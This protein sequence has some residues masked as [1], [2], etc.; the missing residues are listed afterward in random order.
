MDGE[1]I[2][3]YEPD[4]S[5]KKGYL[6]IFGEIFRELNDNRWLTY[7]L[8]KRDFVSAYKQSFIGILWVVIIPIVSLGTFMILNRSG[9]FSV[10]EIKVPYPVYALLGMSFWQIF[11]SGLIACSNS[12]TKAGAMI[13]KINFSKKSLVLAAMGQSAISFLIQACLVVIVMALYRIR[14]NVMALTFP[15][16]LVP[17]F[18]FTISFGFIFSLLSAIMRDI[19]NMLSI[20]MTFLMFLTP[21]LYSRPLTGILASTTQYNPLYYLIS[22]P[23]DIILFGSSSLMN[24]YLIVGA[25]SIVAFIVFIAAFHLTETRIA[26]RV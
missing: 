12:L 14:P 8:F 2:K 16:M 17:I 7:Q 23:R 10:G 4:N 13:V 11:S 20:F 15:L 9:V 21:V 25:L 6:S 19:S 26:E 22:V 5:L 1:F 3:T 24:G 18:I